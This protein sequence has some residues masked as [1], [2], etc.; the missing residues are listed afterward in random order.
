ML[1][2]DDLGIV[3]TRVVLFLVW[4][5]LLFV[6]LVLCFVVLVTLGSCLVCFDI[7]FKLGAWF[8]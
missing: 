4:F 8:V 5:L 2:F 6:C 7:G 1:E 3:L